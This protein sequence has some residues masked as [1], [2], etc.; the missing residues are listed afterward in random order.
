MIDPDGGR[1]T[2]TLDAANNL[3]GLHNP[4]NERA[5]LI[6]DALNRAVTITFGNTATQRNEFNNA[7]W[8]TLVRHAKND[9]TILAARLSRSQLKVYK[10]R[11][12]SEGG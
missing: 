11:R 9:A 6:Y 1:F 2:Y 4:S 5:T 3:T 7:G 8:Q 10:R 12:R